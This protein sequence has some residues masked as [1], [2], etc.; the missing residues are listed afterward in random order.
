MV[1]SDLGNLLHLAALPPA[2]E[3]LCGARPPGNSVRL[4]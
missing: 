3:G 1:F 4:G 2:K